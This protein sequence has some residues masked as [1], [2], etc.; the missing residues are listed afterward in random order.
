MVTLWSNQPAVPGATAIRAQH[1][2]E[3]RDAIENAR[4][5]YA[6]PQPPGWVP[7]TDDPATDSTPIRV[8][9]FIQLYAAIQQLWDKKFL[10]SMGGWS[11]R[12][13]ANPQAGTPIYAADVNDLR[14]WFNS[15]E[16]STPSVL[17][18]A[19]SISGTLQGVHWFNP[20]HPPP[21]KMPPTLW[22]VETV[23]GVSDPSQ[24]FSY[25]AAA[26]NEAVANLQ[27]ARG[28]GYIVSN[29]VR[30]DW[31]TQRA[32]PSPDN[33][34]PF[35]TYEAARDNWIENFTLAAAAF[36][37]AGMQQGV[38]S[39]FIA[40]NEPNIEGGI[41]NVHYAE[42][43]NSLYEAKLLNLSVRGAS[44][45]AAGPAAWSG[46]DYL[47]WLR[48][49][50]ETLQYCDGFAIH[51]YQTLVPSPSTCGPDPRVSCPIGFCADGQFQPSSDSSFQQFRCQIEQIRPYWHGGVPIYITE[52]NTHGFQAGEPPETMGTP[53]QNYHEATVP[54]ATFMQ[55]AYQAVRTYNAGEHNGN[56]AE[57][58]PIECLCWF[59]DAVRVPWDQ[60][61]LSGS[62]GDLPTARAHF[63][64]LTSADVATGITV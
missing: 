50:A 22:N 47:E 18:R 31:A 3:L 63:V 32:V 55:A 39:I 4:T 5:A 14:A 11:R 36:Y 23:I 56:P 40:G 42:A 2:N 6:P 27:Q 9:H 20:F 51:T 37:Q 62:A 45:L 19:A 21:L 43:F 60:Y 8:G 34:A 26:V 53:A 1:I 15:F 24:G 44:Y 46:S 54:G 25:N 30:L 7:W 59:V 52:F 17:V 38:A 58:P 41:G 13:G 12:G 29:I 33:F 35:A 61:A 49:M 16:L 48:G 57:Y 10:G 64:A 28:Q